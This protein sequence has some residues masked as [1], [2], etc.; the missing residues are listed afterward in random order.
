M[1]PRSTFGGAAEVFRD[2]GGKEFTP[3]TKEDL[4]SFLLSDLDICRVMPVGYRDT[5]KKYNISQCLMLRIFF[6]TIGRRMFFYISTLRS[7]YRARC[8]N[9]KRDLYIAGSG[10][11]LNVELSRVAEQKALEAKIEK[12]KDNKLEIALGTFRSRKTSEH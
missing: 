10:Q 5:D 4:R 3:S 12:L 11:K 2:I 9:M 8:I 7:I 1:V 6:K